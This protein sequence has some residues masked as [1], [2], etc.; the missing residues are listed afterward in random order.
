M[1]GHVRET[2]PVP[3]N[4][5]HSLSKTDG[6]QSAESTRWIP[7]LTWAYYEHNA[8]SV[9]SLISAL[10]PTLETIFTGET[11]LVRRQRSEVGINRPMMAQLR[12]PGPGLL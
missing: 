12:R 9:S 8:I 7:A 5:A 11:L 10:P 1:L 3:A 6:V 2:L 4:Q